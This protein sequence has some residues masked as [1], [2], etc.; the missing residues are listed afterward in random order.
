MNTDIIKKITPLWESPD[1]KPYKGSLINWEAYTKDPSDIGCMCAQGQ[2]LHRFDGWSPEMLRAPEGGQY[3]ADKKVA[4]LLDI[5][6]AHSALLRIVNDTVDGAPLIV[7]THPELI[8]GDQAEALLAFWRHIDGITPT[9]WSNLS[10]DGNAAWNAAWD[11]AGNAAAEI[12]GGELM[13][14]RGQPFFFLPMFGFEN[15]AAILEQPQ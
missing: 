7:L 8:I 6:V 13:S 5:S 2:I 4:E 14:Q 9:D 15:P 10:A 3:A 11:A 1:G 12:Q